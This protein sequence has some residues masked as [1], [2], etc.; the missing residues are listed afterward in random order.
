MYD[1]GIDTLD[2]PILAVVGSQ[3]SGKSSILE[4]LV[5]RDFLPRGT[6]IVTRRPLVLQL[7]NI[8]PNSPLIEEDDNSV[9]SHDEVTKVSGFEAGTKPL[10]YKDKERNHADEWGEFLHIPGKRFYDFDDIKRE[11][12]NET[13]RIAGK[14]KGISKI[15]INL[16]VFSPHVLNLTLVDLP[17]ITKVPIGEQPPDIEKQIKNLI[18]DYIAT[19]SYTHLD[20]YKRQEYT[21]A[22]NKI[23]RHFSHWKTACELNEEANKFAEQAVMK[24]KETFFYI[25]CD[26]RSKYSQMANNEAESFRNT[27][28]LFRS[29]QQWIALT[30]TLKEQ[31]R[32]ADQAF[33]NKMFRRIIKAQENWKHL[34]TISIESIKLISLRSVL[35]LWKLKHREMNYVGLKRRVFEGMKQKFID[36]EYKK[37][38]SKEVRSLSLLRTCF[39]RWKKKNTEREDKLAA[40][41]VLENKFIKRK[42]L[43]KLNSLFQYTQQEAVVKSKLD[44]TL[45]RC[46]FEKMWLK[47][48]E[49]HLHLYSIISLKET[50]LVKDIFHSWKKLLYTDLKASDYSRTSLL[51]NTLRSWKLKVKLKT[52]EQKRKMR[53][54]TRA[55]STWRKRIQYGSCLLYTSRCV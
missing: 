35:H 45:L 28:L 53:I 18:L 37:S 55:Y 51:K 54:K 2:L 17:G 4:T 5:G 32:L 7:N 29:F 44:Q 27:W 52:S 49:D 38:I 6:G 25:W 8:P 20:V 22:R 3:S 40:L 30:Q 46:V 33:L 23:R 39:C 42:F 24:I 21:Y 36:Y 19:V 12:E 15:P 11:I 48:F 31:A 10:E 41:N 34:E 1:S 43:R 13:A 47:R 14:D 26:R 9:N 50:N 16:K